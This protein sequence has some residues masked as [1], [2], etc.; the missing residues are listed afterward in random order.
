MT[1]YSDIILIDRYLQYKKLQ[2]K[3]FNFTLFFSLLASNNGELA[4]FSKMCRPAIS[5]NLRCERERERKRQRQKR[6][7]LAQGSRRTSITTHINLI[8]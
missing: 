7:V 2:N 8:K 6:L 3:R 4:T 5:A 1:H